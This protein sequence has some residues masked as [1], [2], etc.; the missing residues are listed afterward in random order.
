MKKKSITLIIAA[1][2]V[3]ALVGGYYGS[4]AWIKAHPKPSSVSPYFAE[5][6]PRLTDFDSSKIVKI[7]LPAA[8][9]TLESNNGLWEVPLRGGVKIAIDQSAVS[10]KLWSIAS[11]WAESIIEEEPADLQQYGLDEPQSRAIITDSDGKKAELFF[12]S[13]TPTH[14]SYYVQTTDDKAVYT[15][16]NYSAE[17]FLF[18]LDSIRDRSLFYLEAE[19]VIRRFLLDPGSGGKTIDIVPRPDDAYLVSNF[20]QNMLVSPYILRRGVASDKF[21]PFLEP[22]QYL[23]INEFIDDNPASLAPYGLDKPG[24]LFIDIETATLDLLFGRD[25]DGVLYVKRPGEPGVFTV[26]GLDQIVSM[27]PF[28]IADKF[29]LIY[30]IDNVDTFTVSGE[31]R[32]LIADVKGTGDE[33]EFFLNGKRTAD[34]E[35]R[36]YYQAVIGLLADSEYPGDSGK[37]DS[38]PGI[39]IEFSL[40]DPSGAKP[41]VTLVPY[42]RDF[43][44]TTQNGVTEFVVSRSQVRNIFETADK[45]VYA[46]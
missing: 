42:N 23:E 36:T 44:Q 45:M 25:G 17:N 15:V 12:G 22:L 41:S 19:P 27:K 21:T 39:R 3:A 37:T 20:S 34:K 29:I 46:E 9:F 13:M 30:N 18:T 24:R 40:R 16:S 10:N 5:D 7:E 31:G 35:F 2:V 28:E 8:G 14:S 4:R 1:A 33:A 32:T 11:L 43:Y 26:N 38:G 6:T